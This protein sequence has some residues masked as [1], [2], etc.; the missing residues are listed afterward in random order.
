MLCSSLTFR[1]ISAVQLTGLS[2]LTLL[3]A[4]AFAPLEISDAVSERVVPLHPPLELRPTA[5]GSLTLSSITIPANALVS[6]RGTDDPG[7]WH[8]TIEHGS[9]AVTATAAGV[10]DVLAGGSV[11]QTVAFGRGGPVQL[12]AGDGPEARLDLHVTPQRVDSLLAGRLIPVSAVTFDE[13]VQDSTP[14]AFG[15]MRG[16]TSSVLEG[17]VF[18][19]SLAGRESRLRPRDTLEM[20]LTSAEVRELRPEPNGLRVSVSGLARNLRLGR[21]GGLQTLRPSYLEWVAEHHALQ[22]AWGAAA[23]LFALF[24]GGVKWWQQFGMS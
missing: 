6:I 2:R 4:G 22:L 24:L 3:Q 16:R 12:R 9:A 8:L 19:V 11:A 20:D 13:A 15:V 7:T 14:G 1:P 17:S 21:A 10:L 23:W 18:N 5:D